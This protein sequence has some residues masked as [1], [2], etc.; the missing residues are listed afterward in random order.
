[1]LFNTIA[2]SLRLAR[3]HVLSRR[4]WIVTVAIIAIP[5]V[6]AFMASRRIPE[7]RAEVYTLLIFLM[8]GGILIPYLAAFLGSSIVGDE[9]EGRTL[10]YLWTRPHSRH[11]VFLWEYLFIALWIALVA[12]ITVALSF[13]MLYSVLGP[14]GIQSNMLMALWD[15]I[16]IASGGAAYAA[17]A[18]M[19]STVLKSPLTI[20]IVYIAADNGVQ[21]MPGFLKLFFVRHYQ[22]A[23]SSDPM[24]DSPQ[25][26]FKFLAEN[27]TTSQ[28]AALTLAAIA[29]V[30][31][32]AGA[33]MLN[34]REYVKN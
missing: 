21:F 29:F 3:R 20:M 33:V 13:V 16:A 4:R 2:A 15:S 18:F 14:A 10:V 12:A 25:G 30:A 6:M 26:F 32:L 1:M 8:I 24:S 28:S 27:Q 19:L 22:L 17:I 7:Q 11:T 23:L 31:L 34:K 9:I 5:A